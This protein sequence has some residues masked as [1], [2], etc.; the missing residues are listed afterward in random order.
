MFLKMKIEKDYRYEAPYCE[1]LSFNISKEVKLFLSSMF[2][3]PLKL[4]PSINKI[5]EHPWLL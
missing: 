2:K 1:K 3:L 4:R 5:I